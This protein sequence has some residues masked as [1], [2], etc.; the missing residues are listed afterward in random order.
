MAFEDDVWAIACSYTQRSSRYSGHLV[1]IHS[2][3]GTKLDFLKRFGRKNCR[4]FVQG[5]EFVVLKDSK[6][7]QLLIASLNS[8]HE[9]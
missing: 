7:M 4:I 8:N 2:R 6:L 5:K 3:S 1:D 9:E